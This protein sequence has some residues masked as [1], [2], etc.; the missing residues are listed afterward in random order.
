MATK[1]SFPG[2][3]PFVQ[4]MNCIG[5]L[6]FE[7]GL[8]GDLDI[9]VSTTRMD[10]ATTITVYTPDGVMRFTFTDEERDA[11]RA[12]TTRRAARTPKGG[13]LMQGAVRQARRIVEAA[14]LSP[15]HVRGE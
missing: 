6:I 3:T 11:R 9:A 13:R 8:R 7:R 2:P 14:P 12:A 1:S 4:A 15:S 10:T 5:S